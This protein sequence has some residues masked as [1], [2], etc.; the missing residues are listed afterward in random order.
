MSNNFNFYRFSPYEIYN[1]L[2]LKLIYLSGFLSE[3]ALLH[4]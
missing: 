3:K 2:N 4:S 1:Q